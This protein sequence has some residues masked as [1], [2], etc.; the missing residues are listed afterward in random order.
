MDN[1]SLE[2]G[3]LLGDDSGTTTNQNN[4]PLGEVAGDESTGARYFFNRL[5]TFGG[6][7]DWGGGVTQNGNEEFV[8]M[9]FARGMTE[10][11]GLNYES[12]NAWTKSLIDS[13]VYAEEKS[14][15]EGDIPMPAGF[16]REKRFWRVTIL[17]GVMGIIMGFMGVGFMNA[18]EYV[19]KVWIDNGEFDDVEDCY[20]NAGKLYWI[21]IPSLTGLV[22][23]LIRWRFEYPFNLP[24]LFAEIRDY[25]VEPKW[26][27]QTFLLS[28][29][30][31]AGG[32]NLGPEQALSN[33]GGGLATYVAEHYPQDSMDGDDRK[34]LVLSGMSAALG[35]LFPTPLLAVL[36][37]HELGSPP[38]AYM[39]SIVILS[40][41][42]VVS[43]VLYY[44]LIEYTKV[45]Y[46]Q[47]Q[48]FLTYS[49][50]FE[51]SQCGTA[52]FI[53]IISGVI[54]LTQVIV[55]G[56]CK[57]VFTRIRLRLERN[58]FMQN[59]IP[60]VLGGL[61]IGVI[62]YALPLTVGS[63]QLALPA[64]IKYGHNYVANPIEIP[65]IPPDV[66][67]S[68]IP[69]PT[70]PKGSITPGLLVCTAFAKLFLL[71]VSM[72]CG[73]VGGFV[74]PTILIGAI[75]GVLFYQWF[76][77]LPL[78]MCVACFISAVPAGIVPM[79]FTLA[80][81]TIFILFNGL[82]Q[83][84]PVY[85]ATLMSYTVVCGTGIFTALALRSQ[86]QMAKEQ[87][88]TQNSSR[89]N[90]EPTTHGNEEK[91]FAVD[92]YLG[93][94]GQTIRRQHAGSAPPS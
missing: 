83:T 24:G 32:A 63:G 46:F 68:D 82:Y 77:T 35:A 25:H 88:V 52:V 86:K 71:G 34:L 76:S 27:P 20:Y 48:F 17:S 5:S 41:G 23:G 1:N 73:F 10:A 61:L 55:L 51:L 62:N 59:I 38:R 22:V 33:L 45:E 29:A 69:I 58:S 49:W 12:D 50:N 8:G 56:I 2:T 21:A 15:R 31:L 30:S 93:A 28:A 79:P 42:A 19:P 64:V 13:Y 70:L 87:Q 74:F 72:N 4:I 7:F 26:S 6:I 67:P 54:S 53:G 40:T 90:S 3:L 11:L 85:I 81:L 84:V 43:F 44:W 80:G 57:Q 47:R 66:I 92:R 18:A 75:S 94:T 78:G 39:E 60:P 36:M 9:S 16:A 37:I 65:P 89:G 91:S 14:G